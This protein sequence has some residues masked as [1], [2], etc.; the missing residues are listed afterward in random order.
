MKKVAHAQSCAEAVEQDLL[1]AYP[2]IKICVI[3]DHLSWIP[4]HIPHK[5]P[6][7]RVFYPTHVYASLQEKYSC[8]LSTNSLAPGHYHAKIT[9]PGGYL[10]N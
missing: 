5:H 6:E 8:T 4:Y 9:P 1:A 2:V 7:K 3:R 10:V